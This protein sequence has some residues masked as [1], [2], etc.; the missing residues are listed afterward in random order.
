MM[1]MTNFGKAGDLKIKSGVV[2]LE[3]IGEPIKVEST[4][5]KLPEWNNNRFTMSD[6]IANPR[7]YS[8]WFDAFDEV[9]ANNTQK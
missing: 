4:E 7:N 8:M 9:K 3:P 6:M 2:C 5:F 1:T